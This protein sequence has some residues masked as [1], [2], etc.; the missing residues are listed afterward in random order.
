MPPKF[1]HKLLSI[2]IFLSHKF[3]YKFFL[4]DKIKTNL[5]PPMSPDVT[6]GGNEEGNFKN[7]DFF[8]KNKLDY[9]HFYLYPKRV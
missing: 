9:T 2:L 7:L 4:A 1:M 5:N 3:F 8:T 6:S